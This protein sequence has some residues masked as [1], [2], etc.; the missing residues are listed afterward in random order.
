MAANKKL[1]KKSGKSIVLCI[2]GMA[3]SGKST[4]AR[5]LAE[6]YGLKYYS[7]G[8]ALKM[9]AEEEGYR[10]LKRGWWESREGLRFL[11]RREKNSKFDKAVDEKLLELAKQGNVILDSWTMP[12]LAKKGFKIWLEASPEKRAERIAKRDKISVKEALKALRIKER[13]T[14]AIYKKLYGFKL[15]EDF[16]PF[17]VILDTE[18]LD[19]DEVFE[20]LCMVIDN[21]W[22]LENNENL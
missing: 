21:L 10:I 16:S 22:Q 12:W 17:H 6:K 20:V 11:E 5:R 18:Y 14:K 19:A 15:G 1:E 2:S 7:G 13:G 4:L 3:G 8:D 9:L